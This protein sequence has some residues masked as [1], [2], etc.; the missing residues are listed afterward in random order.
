MILD[1]TSYESYLLGGFLCKTH[2]YSQITFEEW[3]E[4]ALTE[5]ARFKPCLEERDLETTVLIDRK[6][7][8]GVVASFWS[9]PKSSVYGTWI[10]RKES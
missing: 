5:W 4:T 6:I 3:V 7:Y 8:S 2:Y 1:S 9:G 10:C